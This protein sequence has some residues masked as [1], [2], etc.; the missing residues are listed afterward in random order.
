M[1]FILGNFKRPCWK[2]IMPFL[3]M[4]LSMFLSIQLL[5]CSFHSPAII[6]GLLFPRCVTFLLYYDDTVFESRTH[7]PRMRPVMFTSNGPGKV[8]V[9]LYRYWRIILFW[10]FKFRVSCCHTGT[11]LIH[12]ATSLK[13]IVAP[14]PHKLDVTKQKKKASDAWLPLKCRACTIGPTGELLFEGR[15][16]LDGIKE[17]IQVALSPEAPIEVPLDVLCLHA[18]LLMELTF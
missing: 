11:S 4:A 5:C 2:L 6:C 9:G 13:W 14:F 1:F 17:E 16:N 18:W 3:T 7:R 10:Y 15:C 12:N 8:H